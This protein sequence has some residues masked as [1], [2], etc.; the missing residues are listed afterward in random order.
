[1]LPNCVDGQDDVAGLVLRF[2]VPR[3]LDNVLQ[4]VA[5]IDDRPELPRLDEPLS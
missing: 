4:P 1:M 5:P 2:D 3:R